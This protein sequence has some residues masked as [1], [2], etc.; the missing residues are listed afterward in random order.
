MTRLHRFEHDGGEYVVV[1]IPLRR[2]AAFAELNRAEIEVVE[3]ALAGAP[4][5]E[6]A[7][8]RGV[9]V[10]TVANQLASAFRKLGVGSVIEI[11]S[12]VAAETTKR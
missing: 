5:R 12:L 3:A 8:A 11:A 1:S 6:I 4:Q 2:P 7:R 9:S 10:R